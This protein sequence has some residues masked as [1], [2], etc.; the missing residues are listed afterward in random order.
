MAAEFGAGFGSV[1]AT[2][3]IGA[4]YSTEVSAG[5]TINLESSAPNGVYYAYICVPHVKAE[6]KVQT[7]TLNHT[8]WYTKYEKTIAYMPKLNMEYLEL[9]KDS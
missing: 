8:G 4:S 7:C 9:R 1:T 2:V 6:Y 5:T 3:E